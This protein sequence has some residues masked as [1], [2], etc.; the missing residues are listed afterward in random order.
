MTSM[1]IESVHAPKTPLSALMP[2]GP[3]VTQASDLIA[4]PAIG[5]GGH[6]AGLLVMVANISE[7]RFATERVVQ[8]HRTPAGHKKDM[9]HPA[10]GQ[11]AENIV[12]HAH[13]RRRAEGGFNRGGHEN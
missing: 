12:G 2:P 10:I 4:D 11:G 8:M 1:G 7:A 6:R 9:A 13:R 3:L 5:L